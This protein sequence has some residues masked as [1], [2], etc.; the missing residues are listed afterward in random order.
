MAED[1]IRDVQ[2]LDLRQKEML[3]IAQDHADQRRSVMEHRMKDF[4]IQVTTKTRTSKQDHNFQE[5][6]ESDLAGM[7]AH[8]CKLNN[9]E[10]DV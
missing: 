2:I 5:L 10:T 1:L 8:N 9:Q 4:C 3:D 6:W 7:V